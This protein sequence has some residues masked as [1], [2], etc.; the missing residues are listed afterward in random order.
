MTA[1]IAARTITKITNRLTGTLGSS[2]DAMWVLREEKRELDEKIKVIEAKITAHEEALFERMDK[3]ETSKSQGKHA[4]ASITTSVVGS[5]ED[6]DALWK[7]IIKG[8]H[9]HMLQKRISEPAYR[10]FMERGMKVPGV[11]PFTKR[12]INLRSLQP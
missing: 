1:D 6:W 11:A 10:E 8:K 2:I 4:S 9:T 5:V 12:R 3:E 7:F